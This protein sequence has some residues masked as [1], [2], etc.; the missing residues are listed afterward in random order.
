MSLATK[1]YY[2]LVAI[3]VGI[4]LYMFWPEF[5]PKPDVELKPVTPTAIPAP[6]VPSLPKADIERTVIFKTSPAQDT[7]VV[8]SLP[9]NDSY[10]DV[11]WKDKR[12]MVVSWHSVSGKCSQIICREKQNNEWMPMPDGGTFIFNNGKKLTVKFE[13][14]PRPA[15][16]P[17]DPNPEWIK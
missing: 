12:N 6:T 5:F 2:I 7:V 16:A 15:T 17:L 3:A 4:T 11:S 8:F 9:Y 1:L 13:N 10:K 14:E